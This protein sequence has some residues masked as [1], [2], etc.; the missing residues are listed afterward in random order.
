MTYEEI[1]ELVNKLEICISK[2]HNKP[3]CD[4][5]EY[6]A[7][8]SKDEVD[9]LRQVLESERK[10]FAKAREFLTKDYELIQ[11]IKLDETELRDLKLEITKLFIDYGNYFNQLGSLEEKARSPYKEKLA[12][13]EQSM[14]VAKS[15]KRIE[16][17]LQI[18]LEKI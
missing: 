17:E 15:L 5:C 13:K 11:K 4:Y 7:K 16:N 3:K 8:Q 10:T 6:V 12:S 2:L 14:E 1:D 9:S 18:L